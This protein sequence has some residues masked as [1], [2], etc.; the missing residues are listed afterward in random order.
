MSR[1]P[2]DAPVVDAALAARAEGALVDDVAVFVRGVAAAAPAVG[3]RRVRSAGGWASYTGLFGSR[4]QGAG[5]DGPVTPVDIDEAERFYDDVGVPA[6][7]EVCPLADDS[8]W[9]ELAKR[10]YRLVGFRNVYATDPR[11]VG[12]SAAAADPAAIVCTLVDGSGFEAWSAIL[13]DGFG[14]HDD[15]MRARVARWNRMLSDQ[16]EAALFVATLDGQGVGAANVLVHGSIA[17]FGGTTTL[18]PLRR[19]GVQGAL[20]AARLAH[21]YTAGCTLAVVTADPGGG[22]A[23]NV[24][25]AG[26]RLLY[27][28]ARLRRPGGKAG[29][30]P[31]T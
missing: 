8:L 9:R 16:P 14:Y 24:E 2:A 28:N 30:S 27:T 26:F 3:A 25:R 4:V 11:L 6:E 19:R 20:L 23:R 13:L 21:A 31:R 7:F 15:E 29:R 18:P 5:L 22:S 10:S 17:S 12:S 1:R